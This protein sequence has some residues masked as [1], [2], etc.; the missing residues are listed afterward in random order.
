MAEKNALHSLW[1]DGNTSKNPR[2]PR[3]PSQGS[4]AGKRAQTVLTPANLLDAVRVVFGGPIAF[5]PC[6]ADGSLVDPETFRNLHWSE[7]WARVDELASHDGDLRPDGAQAVEILRYQRKGSDST[8]RARELARVIQ[9]EIRAEFKGRSG[10]AAPWPDRTFVNPPYGDKG[11]ECLL[12]NFEDFCAAFARATTEVAFLCP[13]RSHRKWWR[14]DILRAADAIV[15]LDPLK[16]EGFA[17]TF[18]APLCLAYK[19]PHVD[20]VGPAFVKL[21]DTTIAKPPA[22][23]PGPLDWS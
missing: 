20:R 12:A 6:H 3:I 16:F 14:R 9:A 21:G 22:E 7:I 23:L 13:V 17:Q 2:D 15:F 18:P 5:D 10:H 1:G 4:L 11:P 19:G 8:P